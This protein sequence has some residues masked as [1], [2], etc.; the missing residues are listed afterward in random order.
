MHPLGLSPEPTD[1]ERLEALHV[2]YNCGRIVRLSSGRFAIFSPWTNNDGIDL[3]TIGDLASLENLIPT[4]AECIEWTR[5]L[6]KPIDL[7]A[8]LGIAKPTQPPPPPIKR[9]F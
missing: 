3:I 5:E 6:H 4:E 1:D 9:R 7:A 8:M 2:R